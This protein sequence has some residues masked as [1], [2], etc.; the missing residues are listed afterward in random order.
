VV[1]VDGHIAV[2]LHVEVEHGVA[3]QQRQQVVE[4]WHARG[5]RRLAAPV[6]GETQRDVR[7]GGLAFDFCYAVLSHEWMPSRNA[8]IWESVP[9]VIRRKVRVKA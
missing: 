5:D 1:I 4:K 2:H 7:L 9:T 3:R 6:D 8:A